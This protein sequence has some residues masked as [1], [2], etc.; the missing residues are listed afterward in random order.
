MKEKCF[1]HVK[2]WIE[3]NFKKVVI[4]FSY[5]E[6]EISSGLLIIHTGLTFNN[7]IVNHLIYICSTSNKCHYD[8]IFHHIQWIVETNCTNLASNI[9]PTLSVADFFVKT[10]HIT[11]LISNNFYFFICYIRRIIKIQR[12]YVICLK[13]SLVNIKIYR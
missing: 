13:H 3:Y 12:T 4:I 2:I 1:C 10:Y 5:E 8:F 9:F 11:I 6:N 7:K